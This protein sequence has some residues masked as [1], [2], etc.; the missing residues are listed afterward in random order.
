MPINQPPTADAGADQTNECTSP[1]GASLILDGSGSTDPDSTPGTNDDIVSFEWFED[2]GLPIEEYLG[3]GEMLE[4]NLGLGQHNITL[5]VTDSFDL[6]DT[7]DLIVVVQDTT[8]PE[9]SITVNPDTLWPP[10][11]KLVLITTSIEVSDICDPSPSVILTSVT[12]NEPD[13]GIADG[14]TTGDIVVDEEGNIYLRA[15]RSGKGD[16]RIYTIIHTAADASDNSAEVESIVTVP[17]DI[18]KGKK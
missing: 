13:N 14:N 15:E 12:S 8:Q 2:Y 5:L 1:A 17:H 16:G 6:T 18:G 11:H 3:E 9:L 4:V 10:N 7:D